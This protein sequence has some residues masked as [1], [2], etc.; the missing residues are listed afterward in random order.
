MATDQQMANR[1][2]KNK[3]GVTRLFTIAGIV[4]SG[5]FMPLGDQYH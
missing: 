3:E 1:R 5:E 4:I 2:Q